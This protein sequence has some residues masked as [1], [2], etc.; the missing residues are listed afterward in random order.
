MRARSV[1]AM[2]GTYESH[3]EPTVKR[4]F[5]FASCPG[6]KDAPM[7]L[8]VVEDDPSLATVLQLSITAMNWGRP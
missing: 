1:E 3:R 7:R 2:G 4:A 8:L 6:C 5:T